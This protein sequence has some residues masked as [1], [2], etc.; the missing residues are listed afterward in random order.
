MSSRLFE[1]L[2]HAF[3]DWLSGFGRDFLSQR[4]QLLRLFRER[5]ELFA[6]LGRRKLDRLGRRLRRE[7]LD[8]VVEGRVDISATGLD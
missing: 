5:F 8:R 7:K 1:G 3:S 4:R 6:Q 2:V